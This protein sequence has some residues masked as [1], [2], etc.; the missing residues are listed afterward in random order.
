MTI[1]PTSA[2]PPS[3]TH[4]GPGMPANGKTRELGWLLEDFRAQVPGVQGAFLATPDGLV[5]AAAGLSADEADRAAAF[6]AALY[7]TGAAGASITST[8][9]GAVQQVIVQYDAQYAIL[10]STPDP[11]PE[12]PGRTTAAGC[13]LGVLAG[14]D[15]HTG[16]VGDRMTALIVSVARHLVTDT[17]TA[18]TPVQDTGITNEGPGDAR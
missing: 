1:P 15:T 18:D 5:L 12:R 17:R 9:S 8:P 4:T 10:M 14:P 6:A 11:R 7:S 2:T 16:L 13:V 3:T